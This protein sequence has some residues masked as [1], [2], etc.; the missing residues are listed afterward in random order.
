MFPTALQSPLAIVLLLAGA[1]FIVL[2]GM[3]LMADLLA[4]ILLAYTMAVALLPMVKRLEQRGLSRSL[5]LAGVFLTAFVAAGLTVGYFLLELQQ[6]AYRIPSY[7]GMLESRFAQFEAL[8]GHIG[9]NLSALLGGD[10][11]LRASLGLISRLLDLTASLAI[12]LLIL[13]AMTFDFPGVSRAYY[14]RLGDKKASSQQVRG[15]LVEIQ[16]HYRL[17]SVSNLVSA[18]AVTAAYLVFRVDFALLWGLSTFFL[19]Y[20]P[21]FGM[22]LSFIPPLLMAFVQYGIERALA[23]LLVSILLNG[24]MD[25]FVAPMLSRRGLALRTSTVLLS[26]LV[27][28]WVFGPLGALLAVPMTLVIRRLLVSAE[29][30][31]PLAYAISTEAYTLDAPRADTEGEPLEPEGRPDRRHGDHGRT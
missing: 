27:W 18:V 6:L 12:F 20:I 16:T 1:T 31:M 10:R 26:S 3:R 14:G 30:T 13:L 4:P 15:V 21:R 2:A 28:I 5:S 24:L 19:S 7:Q 25:N 17:Q 22:L 9:Y 23:L 8:A 11:V 29:Q